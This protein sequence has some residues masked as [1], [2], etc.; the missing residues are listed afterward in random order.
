MRGAP[1][2]TSELGGRVGAA[3]RFHHQA[4]ETARLRHRRHEDVGEDGERAFFDAEGCEENLLRL[5]LE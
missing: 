3:L 2:G 5:L 4:E 1:D